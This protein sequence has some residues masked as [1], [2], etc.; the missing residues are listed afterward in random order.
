MASD[1]K[2]AIQIGLKDRASKGL[3]AIGAQ[4][5]G[6]SSGL[7]SSLNSSG[8]AVGALGR[9]VDGLGG[10]VTAVFPA[11]GVP[12]MLLGT[13]IKAALAAVSAAG[14]L[15]G[16]VFR[17]IGSAIASA[18]RLGMRA[19][20]GL[21][22]KA[23]SVARAFGLIGLAAAAAA[24][25]VAKSSLDAAMQM[26]GFLAKLTTAT[27]SETAGKEWLEWARKFAAT[28]PFDV[29]QVTD[30]VT[31]LLLQGQDPRQVLTL[32]GNMAG[33][34]NKPLTD[35]VEAYLDASRGEW[36]RI[37][38]FGINPRNLVA[39]GAKKAS[40]GGIDAQTEEGAAAAKKAL[41]ALL[42][43]RYGGGMAAMMKTAAGAVSNLGDQIFKLRVA[44]GNILLPVFKD[45]VAW[46]QEFFE[47]L[48]ELGVA[49]KVGGFLKAA[50]E[51]VFA[52]VQAIGTAVTMLLG[53]AS[54]ADVLE[55]VLGAEAAERLG[56]SIE[57]LITSA[58][59]LGSALLATFSG[60]TSGLTSDPAGVVAA[61]ANRISAAITWLTDN[62]FA[63]GRIESIA[64]WLTNLA[65]Q[66]MA[67]GGRIVA[68]ITWALTKLGGV[69]N[70]VANI[71]VYFRWLVDWGKYLVGWFYT[72][73]PNLLDT[74]ATVLAGV[75][76]HVLGV[77]QVLNSISA[78]FT[79]IFQGIAAVV[80]TVSSIIVTV[81]GGAIAVILEGIGLLVPSFKEAA[82]ALEG[83]ITDFG[84][85]AMKSWGKIGSNLG[86]QAA[87]S[88]K[89]DEAREKLRGMPDSV[90]AGTDRMRAY[91][92]ANPY[93][94]TMPG[95][96]PKW[97]PN[98]GATTWTAGANAGFM[99]PPAGG[100]AGPTTVNV[101]INGNGDEYLAKKFGG[102]LEDWKRS[103]D[104]KDRWAP[105]SG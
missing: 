51:R 37:K 49:E 13:G 50:A 71:G 19:L 38:E 72:N 100:A 40:S 91:T 87:A 104:R 93:A 23:R 7:T 14:N 65:Q 79:T 42:A 43:S 22:D 77:M 80:L 24:V 9:G 76:D 70:I 2:L 102:I 68:A 99:A 78:V 44:I 105:T 62:V 86:A 31:R 81:F 18:A 60:L 39:F 27:K 64:A 84:D 12:M 69:G 74:I 61:I 55:K 103:M 54:I 56:P 34:M 59:R 10:V 75:G 35:A 33:A 8:K 45:A 32:I 88:V 63:P 29:A 16:R 57:K 94:P 26:E 4:V 97:N 20:G 66:A 17:G 11:L 67:F 30:A 92:G 52:F 101:N 83:F 85:T 1:L 36:E 48:E 15:V 58:Q 47:G 46:A 6:M 73:M 41:D 3:Q 5:R 98:L 89:M 82:H 28:T 53:G 95:A 96:A 25:A 90:R 21:A